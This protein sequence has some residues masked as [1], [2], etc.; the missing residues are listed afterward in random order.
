MSR[1]T[2]HRMKRRARGFTLIELL[3]VMVILAILA[4]LV[5]PRL[6]GRGEQAKIKA[7]AADIA[8]IGLALKLFEVDCGRYPTTS[9]GLQA[10]VQQPNNVQGWNQ[11]G[12][13]EKEQGVP[14]DPWGNPYMYRYPGSHNTRSYDLYSYGPDGQEGGGDDIDNWTK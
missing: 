13:L 4:G 3:L 1:Q 14:N 2:T 9:E 10:L 11:L 5:W 12:Y 6:S 8:N 7:A